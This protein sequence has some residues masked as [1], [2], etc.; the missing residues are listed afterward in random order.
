MAVKLQFEAILQN[1]LIYAS[2]QLDFSAG[3]PID[4]HFAAQL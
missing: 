3:H 1:S 2:C 4:G